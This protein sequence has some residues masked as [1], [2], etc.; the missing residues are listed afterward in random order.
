MRGF[1]PGSGPIDYP[2]FYAYIYPQPEA[3]PEASIAPDSAFW[4]AEMR[5]FLL[6]YESVRTAADP[7]DA[8]MAFL[9]STYVASAELAGWD[10]QRLE[11]QAIPEPR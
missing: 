1:W 6:P 11:L 2:A 5:E 10:R 4:S 8:L 7:E 3:L 9:Q